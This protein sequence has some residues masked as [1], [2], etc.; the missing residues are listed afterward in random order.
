MGF[1][2]ICRADMIERG[3][4]QLDFLFLTGDA[5]VD[6]PSFGAAILTRMLEALGYRTGI[7]ARPDINSSKSLQLMGRPRY[8][9]LVSSGVVDS[10]V[11]NYTAAGRKRSEDRYAPGGIGGQRP[12]RALIR[13]CNLVRSQFGEIPLIIGGVEAS[14]RRFAHYDVWSDKVRRSILQDSRADIL[15]Y[16]MGEQPLKTIAD[17]LAR[18]ANVKSIN[19]IRGTCVFSGIDD[20]PND[21]RSWLYENGDYKYIKH[22]GVLKVSREERLL[23]Q[24]EKFVQLPD[25]ETCAVDKYAYALSFLTQYRE[26]DPAKGRVLIQR[27]GKRFLIQNPPQKPMSQKQLDWLYGLPYERKPHSVYDESGGIP[28]IEEVGF[29]VNSHRGCYGGCNFC[30]ITFHQGRIIQNRSE[31]SIL[32]EVDTITKMPDFK[33]Y[34]HDI[35]GPTANFYLPACSKQE[36][37]AV[38]K[39]RQCMFPEPCPSLKR[40][41]SSYLEILRKAR[42]MTGVKKVFIRSGIRY[43]YLLLDKKTN[44]IQELCRYHV[45]G[46]LKVAPEHVS[47]NALHAMGKPPVRIY[48]KFKEL[49]EKTNSELN[50]RQYLVPYLISGHPGCTLNDAIELAV[51]IKNNRVMPE[52][53]QDFYPTPGTVSTTMYYTGIDPFSMQKIHVPDKME[54]RMQR[55]LLQFGKP[56]NRDQVMQ[57]L[58]ICGRTD[59]IGYGHD[60]LIRPEQHKSNRFEKNRKSSNLKQRNGNRHGR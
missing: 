21:Y 17:L 24:N 34:I 16:G 49:Y 60:C 18:G 44:F 12:D 14:L 58:K 42:N 53:V 40:D 51:Y 30:A 59:L 28:A 52:Q 47:V 25:Y 1:L 9:V 35:G 36:S 56:A 27:H 3:W 41:H 10:M 43:D 15:I 7:I 50:M 22:D 13:Y 57:A 2:P 29:S 31:K 6:H 8:G 38:C 39:D 23:P 37:G 55:A 33:G 11:N 48:E 32:E 45:S 4:D 19:N 26:Q 54:K 46:Q 5:Y 20:L